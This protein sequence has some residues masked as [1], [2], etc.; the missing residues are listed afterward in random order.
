[1]KLGT[2][3][4]G[5]KTTSKPTEKQ[6]ILFS[7]D[8]SLLKFLID[9]TYDPFKLYHVNV[10]ESDIPDPGDLDIADEPDKIKEL[11]V[12]CEQSNSNKQN[13][14]KVIEVLS[15]LDRGSQELLVGTLNKNWK[16]GLGVRN[17]LK[18]Y[19]DIVPVFEVQLSHTFDRK[20]SYA[21]IASWSWS[22]KLDGLRCVAIRKSS[23]PFYNKGKW[24]LYSRKGK[25]F[26]TVEHLKE[27]LEEM[28]QLTG[29]TLFDG[30]LYKHGLTFEEVQGPVMAYTQ[31]QVEEMEYH[32][33]VGGSAEDFLK[34]TGEHNYKILA[35]EIS[36][37]TPKLHFVNRGLINTIE[38]V[39]EKLE[40]AF[41]NGYEGIMLRDINKP[42]DYKRSDCLIKLK[43]KENSDDGTGEII[44]DCTVLSIECDSFPVIEDGKMLHENLLVRLWV[45]QADDVECKVGSGFDLPFRRRYTSNPEDLIGK[46]V[47]IR[48]QQWGANGRMRFPRLWRV[49]EDL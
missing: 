21:K 48:H 29:H 37:S 38:E 24:S 22:Y 45:K 42:Y 32:L 47:E 8:C 16:V 4:I 5:L 19:P 14:E 11:L 40:E 17:I 39:E 46:T 26:H 7:Y 9:A 33:F 23:D 27:Q 2:L 1:M 6:D 20:K 28:Y 43:Q 13:R 15:T 18:V 49:R 25:E 30:E 36:E 31:G 34:S 41:A 35:G 44:S 3:L 10:K 12:F